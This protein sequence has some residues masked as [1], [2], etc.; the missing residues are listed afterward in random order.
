MHESLLPPTFLGALTAA[1]QTSPAWFFRHSLQTRLSFLQCAKSEENL[2]A[3]RARALCSTCSPISLWPWTNGRKTCAKDHLQRKNKSCKKDF[4][5]WG[6]GVQ[7]SWVLVTDAFSPAHLANVHIHLSQP[8]A[9]DYANRESKAFVNFFFFLFASMK[10]QQLLQCIPHD[11]KV[12]SQCHGQALALA[13]CT[14]IGL[15]L[16]CPLQ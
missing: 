2:G 16:I 7:L 6:N 4:A 3:G 12:W 13:S 5:E 15:A 8:V 10:K 14:F 11:D 1:L 9:H